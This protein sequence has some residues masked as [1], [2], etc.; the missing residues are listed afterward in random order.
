MKNQ[1]Q[2]FQDVCLNDQSPNLNNQTDKL[3]GCQFNL[4]KYQYP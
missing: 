4:V 1:D 3:H 2:L